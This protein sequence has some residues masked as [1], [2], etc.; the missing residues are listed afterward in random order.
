MMKAALAAVLALSVAALWGALPAA[1]REGGIVALQAWSRPAA[2][3]SNG[4]GYLTLVNHGKADALVG[5][6]SSVARK[7]EL[8]AS[9]MAGGVMSMTTETRAPL[10]AGGQ[11]SFAPGG[12]HLMLVGLKRALHP[13]DR[14]AATL[15]FASGRALR[16]EFAVGTGAGAPMDHMSGH[17]PEAHAMHD[18][19]GMR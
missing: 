18:M 13:G 14:F 9:S 4:A 8:H 12:R 10:P 19:P 7:V 1:A 5:V 6:D 11:L 17:H 15:R 16:V 3:G 2:A